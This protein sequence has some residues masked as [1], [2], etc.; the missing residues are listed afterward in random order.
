L[1]RIYR[2]VFNACLGQYQVASELT[3]S[4]ATQSGSG[5]ANGVPRASRFIGLMALFCL[6]NLAWAAPGDGGNAGANIRGNGGASGNGGSAYFESPGDASSNG[7][8]GNGAVGTIG[9]AGGTGGAVGTSPGYI[10]GTGGNGADTATN[11]AAGGGGGGGAGFFGLSGTWALSS[12]TGGNGGNGG[13]S[14]GAHGGGGGGGG[15]GVSLSNGT[16]SNLGSISG[17]NGGNGGTGSINEYTGAGGGGGHGVSG[18]NL[19]IIN[20]GTISAG[21]GG[22]AATPFAEDG[23]DGAAVQFTGGTNSL[24]LQTGSQID[25]VVWLMDN[26]N[27]TITAENAG[28]TLGDGVLLGNGSVLTVDTQEDLSIGAITG[29]GSLNKTGSSTLFLSGQNSYTGSTTISAG[30]L[31]AGNAGIFSSTAAVTVASGATLDL[32]GFDQG[33]GSLSGAGSV[34]TAG[35]NLSIG[36]DNTSST[37]SGAISGTGNLNKIGSGTLVLDGNSSRSATSVSA[38]RLIV[39]SSAGSSASLS[40][41]VNV[42]SGATLGGHGTIIG[43]IDLASGATLAPGNSI[44]ILHVTGDVTLTGGSVLEIEASPDGTSDRLIATGVVDLG[45]STLSILGGAGTWSLSTHYNLI[46]AGTRVGTFAT[47]TSDLAFLTPTVNYTATSVDLI[48]SRN[49]V[50]FSSMANT[51]NQR[52][53]AASLDSGLSGGVLTAV[54]GLASGQTGAAFDSLSGELH[55]STRSALFDDSRHVREAISQRLQAG[56]AN[57]QVLHRDAAS[58]LTFWLQSYGSWSETNGDSNVADLDRDSRGSFIG[59]DLPLDDTWR[60]GLAVGYGSSDLDVSTR[61]SSADIDSTTLAAYLAGQ[62]DALSL[63]LGAARSWNDI[64]SK[65]DVRVGSLNESVKA[66]YDATTTQAF[67]E[68][69]YTLPLQMLKLE[70]YVGLAHVEV[71]RDGFRERGGVSALQSDSDKDSINYASLGL[72]AQAPLGNLLDRALSLNSGLS[73]QHAFDLPSDQNRQSLSGFEQFSVEGV[74]VARDSVQ[75]QLGLSWQLAPQTNLALGYAGQFG[76]GSRDQGVRLGL[77]VAF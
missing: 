29:D 72:R 37:F 22:L 45:N 65:R 48:L 8:G 26:A 59:A 39:G 18:A 44:G 2:T 53:V 51:R 3:S 35:G 56:H 54:T 34:S 38:G 12:A 5:N 4:R 58:G 19:N 28:L 57:E 63:R 40:S 70:P 23:E 11:N 73:W 50:S 71:D 15:N 9:T 25:G 21:L 1:N 64:S 10:G 14:A 33:I 41:D 60:L 43:D 46:Q 27:A 32:N 55:A 74:P 42:A 67:A 16:L 68:L 47:I 20:A 66:G 7:N 31:L 30:R 49:D 61:R 6:N 17:G 77:A 52:A 76:D 36:G 75:L 24:T 13:N 62:W 69:G